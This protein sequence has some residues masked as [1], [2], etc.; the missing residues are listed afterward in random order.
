ASGP[1]N[2]ADVVVL[3]H[4]NDVRCGPGGGAA[5]PGGPAADYTGKL[6]LQSTVRL[7]DHNNGGDTGDAATAQN[8]PLNLPV[9][10]VATPTTAEGGVCDGATTVNSLLP[11][12][13]VEGKRANFEL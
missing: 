10:C 13:I 11:G 5:C 8:I 12:A 2:D 4:I 1:P 7:T 9:Q 6:V 3:V